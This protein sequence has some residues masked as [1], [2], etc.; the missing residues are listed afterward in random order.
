MCV[1]L[2]GRVIKNIKFSISPL[3]SQSVINLNHSSV[4]G[5]NAPYWMPTAIKLNRRRSAEETAIMQ[6]AITLLN[7]IY[8]N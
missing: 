4:G 2:V 7:N 8:L 6:N 1:L 3:V 5:G